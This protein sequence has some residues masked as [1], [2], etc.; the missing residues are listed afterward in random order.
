MLQN[1]LGFENSLI[2]IKIIKDH[3][4][5]RSHSLL[6]LGHIDNMKLGCYVFGGVYLKFVT[7]MGFI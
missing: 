3:I 4:Q 1:V 2:A 7:A 6:K 5:H